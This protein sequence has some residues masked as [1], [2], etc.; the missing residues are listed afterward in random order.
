MGVAMSDAKQPSIISRR[1]AL[2]PRGEGR[3]WEPPGA[4]QELT[5]SDVIALA[6]VPPPLPCELEAALI[7][8]LTSPSLAGETYASGGDRRE[9]EALTI[10]AQLDVTQAPHL[11]RRFDIGKPDDPVVVALARLAADRRTRLR[12]FIGD[13]RRRAALA[14]TTRPSR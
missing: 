7:A 12:A 10:L 1:T 13:T 14:A 2:I 4:Q 9:R 11:A 3:L 6:R 8:A 5:S